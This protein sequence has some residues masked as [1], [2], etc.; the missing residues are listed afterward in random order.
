MPWRLSLQQIPP[1]YGM[2]APE[3]VFPEVDS[4]LAAGKSLIIL[5]PGSR[6]SA[7]EWGI[8]NFAVLCGL[9]DLSR[10]VIAITGTSAER[11]LIDELEFPWQKS[12]V[13][14]LMGKLSL[15]AFIALLNRANFV[16][17]ASTGP[18]HIASAMGK[19]VVGLYSP[20]RPIWPERWAPVGDKASW[21]SASEHPSPGE[22]LDIRPNDVYALIESRLFPETDNIN[23][24]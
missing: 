17:A 6:G 12:G 5:H 1:L 24:P 4:Q 7:V 9:F 10:Y 14:D 19:N 21:I 18:L 2:Q 15:S 20:K 22:T 3:Q 11:S 23:R 13:I 16:V 8:S